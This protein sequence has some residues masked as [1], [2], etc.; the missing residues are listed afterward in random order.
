MSKM[1][2]KLANSVRQAK[3]PKSG[4]SESV[5]KELGNKKPSASAV[6]PSKSVL[7]KGAAKEGDDRPKIK[8]I[9]VWPD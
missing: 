3:T 8:S 4:E 1:S 7:S 6:S 5:E 9:P 2:S